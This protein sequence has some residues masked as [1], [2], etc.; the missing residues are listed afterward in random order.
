MNYDIVESSI[1]SFA[2]RL[3]AEAV[4]KILNRR[5]FWL[6]GG[7]LS[8]E[9]PNDYDIF[10][11]GNDEKFNFHEI[12]RTCDELNYKVLSDTKNAITVLVGNQKI[13]FCNY[14]FENAKT[15]LRHFDFAHC[16][17]AVRFV[18]DTDYGW[19]VDDIC[20]TQEWKDAKMANSTFYTGISDYP[21]SSLVRAGKFLAQGK[22][23]TRGQYKET[24]I[25]I[26]RRVIER[27]FKNYD[28]FYDQLSSISE[29]LPECLD[30]KA[31]YSILGNE[32]KNL[33][34]SDMPFEE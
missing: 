9:E 2:M 25:K 5:C 21:L 6:A 11:I 32:F 3:N 24:V 12:H 27:G 14:V 19:I 18:E 22:F 13:Q 20:Y 33:G 23:A 7:A 4:G 1:R 10:P 8:P 31:L 16:Q 30:G 26:L 34:S 17:I 28:D 15:M 29:G